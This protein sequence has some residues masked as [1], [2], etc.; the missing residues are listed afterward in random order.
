MLA[1]L[2]FRSVSIPHPIQ[3]PKFKLYQTQLNIFSL[4]CVRN[5]SLVLTEEHELRVCGSNVL[6]RIF[7]PRRGEVG[8]GWRQ[9]HNWISGSI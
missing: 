7:G 9:H 1:T 6:R 5:L 4:S 2:R 8:R 3:E